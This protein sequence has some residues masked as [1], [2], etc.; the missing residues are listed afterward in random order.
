[1]GFDGFNKKWILYGAVA[2]VVVLALLGFAGILPGPDS[3]GG[4]TPGSLG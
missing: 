4:E 2:V 1:M 3:F